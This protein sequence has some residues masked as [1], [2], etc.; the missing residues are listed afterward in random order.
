MT[1]F[2]QYIIN[3]INSILND[4]KNRLHCDS[5][6]YIGSFILLD[7]FYDIDIRLWYSNQNDYIVD[8][9]ILDEISLKINSIFNKKIDFI[10]QIISDDSIS[11]IMSYLA[12]TTNIYSICIFNNTDINYNI[13]DL[14]ENTEYKKQVVNV[15]YNL[16]QNHNNSDNLIDL[17]YLKQCDDIPKYLLKNTYFIKKHHLLLTCY[18]LYNNSYELTDEQINNIN[19]VHSDNCLSTE[20]FNWCK[21]LI[22]DL[23]QKEY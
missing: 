14:V 9:Q 22:T 4:Y 13:F 10:I 11:D 18:I 20:L 3:F 17:F 5:A 21:T 1:S 19:N 12:H 23:Y 6:F 15:L 7:N 16:F 2:K 8:K